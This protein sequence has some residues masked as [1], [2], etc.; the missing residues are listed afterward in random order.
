LHTDDAEEAAKARRA[1]AG[2]DDLRVYD[3]D[4]SGTAT[5]ATP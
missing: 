2:H 3:V 1:L 5:P 4:Q